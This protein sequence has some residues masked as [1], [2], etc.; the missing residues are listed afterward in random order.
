MSKISVILGKENTEKE[1]KWEIAHL[2]MAWLVIL[3]IS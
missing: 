2:E 3:F 1:Y